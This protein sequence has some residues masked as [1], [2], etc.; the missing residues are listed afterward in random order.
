MQVGVYDLWAKSVTSIM[1]SLD[2]F[3]I[4]NTSVVSLPS[5]TLILRFRRSFDA[6]F[7]LETEQ[8][9]LC[10]GARP[11]SELAS[12][13][14]LDARPVH[15][16]RWN[17]TRDTSCCAEGVVCHFWCSLHVAF[18]LKADQVWPCCHSFRAE[19]KARPGRHSVPPVCDSQQ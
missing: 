5:K 14:L 19:A 4:T 13:I 12:R 1:P 8:V 3:T 11:V 7:N 2:M 9:G 18:N 16:L 15:K 17:T 6:T 10:H